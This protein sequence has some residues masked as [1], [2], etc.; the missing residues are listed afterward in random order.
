MGS[1]SGSH[2]GSPVWAVIAAFAACTPAASRP[3][4]LS[5]IATTGREEISSSAWI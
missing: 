2:T 4:W 3:S 5:V 1:R